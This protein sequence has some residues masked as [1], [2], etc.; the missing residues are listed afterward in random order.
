MSQFLY[1][2]VRNYHE[3]TVV[4]LNSSVRTSFER[5]LSQKVEWRIETKKKGLWNHNPHSDSRRISSPDLLRS[6]STGS[7]EELTEK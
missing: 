3:L 1:P 4:F 2:G 6:G 5:E 7:K